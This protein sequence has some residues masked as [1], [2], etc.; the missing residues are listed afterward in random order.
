MEFTNMESQWAKDLPI[1]TFPALDYK[2]E[3][4]A[5]WFYLGPGVQAEVVWVFYWVGHVTPSIL[6]V[7]PMF[8]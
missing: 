7:Y 5:W 1:V 3:L 4:H 2:N 6:S 8:S